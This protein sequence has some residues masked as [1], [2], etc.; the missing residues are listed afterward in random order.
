M[1]LLEKPIARRWARA[2]IALAQDRK[3]LDEVG[4]DLEALAE[5]MESHPELRHALLSPA[6]HVE[7]RRG[8]LNALLDAK[9]AGRATH[10]VT[11]AVV[12]LL[13][14][15]DRVPYLPM[16]C[17]MFRKEA[18]RLVGRVRADVWSAKPL[19]KAEIETIQK[20]LTAQAEKRALGREVV[21]S[22]RVDPGL[23][24]G[25]KARLG[26]VVFD[27]TLKNHLRRIGGQL[28]HGS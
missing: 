19:E 21:V 27:G 15:K 3:A 13:V 24:A 28:S 8:V 10:E 22:T 18:D 17:E 12:M 5:H 20:A 7:Q 26:G 25:V 6:F 1:A 16:L 23:L 14:E 2:V 9:V 11:R 4:A